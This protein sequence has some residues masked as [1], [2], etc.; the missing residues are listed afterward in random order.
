MTMRYVMAW[1]VSI[2][3]FVLMI[4]KSS[5]QLL[6][7]K[8]K[9]FQNCGQPGSWVAE[10]CDQTGHIPFGIRSWRAD[11]MTVLSPKCEEIGVLDVKTATAL[12]GLKKVSGTIRF[13]LFLGQ[14]ENEECHNLK[15]KRSKNILPLEINIHGPLQSLEEIGKVLSDAGMFLQKPNVLD[16]G[17]IY[18][19]PHFLLW[20]EETST[21]LLART[22]KLSG[23]I[24]ANIIEEVM[25]CSNHPLHP[26]MFSQDRRVTSPL[27]RFGLD[28]IIKTIADSVNI[29]QT[30]GR[31]CTFY[32]GSRRPIRE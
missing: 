24:Y 7:G 21:P 9:L 32:D 10:G 19:N 3:P 16:Q 27:K 1:Q 31:R 6:D 25:S 30:S 8:F 20:G 23:E 4:A 28:V 12:M 15:K 26:P 29:F 2:V 11:S 18:R 14:E 5:P 13:S 22:E 17:A